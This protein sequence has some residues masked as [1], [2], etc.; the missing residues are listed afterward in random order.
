MGKRCVAKSKLNAKGKRCSLWVPYLGGVT[1][2][3]HEGL[4]KIRFEGVL[5]AKKPLPA[6]AYR[7]TLQA[8]NS[9]GSA[10]APQH[11]AFK[12]IA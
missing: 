3:G 1:R 4:D 11:P 2:A 5:D 7:L 6:G 9:S 10:I 8:S 12:L